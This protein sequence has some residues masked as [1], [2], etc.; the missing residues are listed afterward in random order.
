MYKAV[1]LVVILLL[2]GCSSIPLS[3]MLEMRSYSKEDFLATQPEQLRAQVLL[4][5]PVRADLDKVQLQLELETGKGSRLYQFPLQLLVEEQLPQVS[6]LFSTTPAKTSYTFKLSEL[7]ITN[8]VEMQQLLAE[9]KTAKL[10]FTISSGLLDILKGAS[11][12]TLTA[13][14]KLS[15]QNDYLTLF[16]DAKLALDHSN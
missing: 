3:T 13:R 6:G 11:S 5:Q 12:V 14:L 9:Q 4:A 8:F 15:E 1:L 7:A 2:T 16:E 10:N